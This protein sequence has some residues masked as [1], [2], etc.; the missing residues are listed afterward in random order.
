GGF[1]LSPYF[2][3][4]FWFLST[5]NGMSR[6]R[7]VDA[8]RRLHVLTTSQRVMWG[9][10]DSNPGAALSSTYHLRFRKGN[11]RLINRGWIRSETSLP[12]RSVIPHLIS[13]LIG[14]IAPSTGAFSPG[15]SAGSRR[16]ARPQD[17]ASAHP[18]GA[19]NPPISPLSLIATAL[20]SR[21]ARS[22]GTFSFRSMIEPFSHKKALFSKVSQANEAPTTCPLSLIAYA[23]LKQSP[24]SVP[25]LITTPL[26][27]S[28]AE[29]GEP[30]TFEKSPPPTTCPASLMALAVM[31]FPFVA[32][33]KSIGLPLSQ[34]N[35][36]VCS[37]FAVVENP[38]T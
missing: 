4:P 11:L 7:I 23:S 3:F 12:V 20:A 18:N 10:F 16:N 6:H 36:L 26:L 34:K 19:A 30:P 17:S 25:K 31:T 15:S 37:S 35:G 29:N 21:T 32:L 28:T 14:V 13:G 5:L 38:T 9:F 1:V 24:G 8:I 22:E 33:N 2:A 27:Q